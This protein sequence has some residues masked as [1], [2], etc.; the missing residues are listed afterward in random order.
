M[1]NATVKL[2][3][4]STFLRKVLENVLK[5]NEKEEKWEM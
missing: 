4:H 2:T 5:E 1:T 3:S